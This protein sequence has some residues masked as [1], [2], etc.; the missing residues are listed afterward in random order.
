MS[1]DIRILETLRVRSVDERDRL[2]SIYHGAFVRLNERTPIHHGSYSE[3]R[4][5]EILEDEE[6]TKFLVYS[7]EELVG[8]TL[9]THALA[10]VP[11]VNAHYFAARYPKSTRAGK[12]F[13]LPAVVIDPSYQ[14]LRRIGGR[15][16]QQ[17]LTSLGEDVVVA[18]DYS[19]SLRR[20]L[21]SFVGRTLGREF[22]GE[23]LD[24]LVYEVFFYT[25]PE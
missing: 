5:H 18:C 10:K 19:E 20:S 8:V 3:Q 13:F 14:D 2:W 7:G 11:W 1:D 6:F 25:D 9:L 15:L 21:P 12:V 16:L 4:F 17:A 24:R 22:K 23:V